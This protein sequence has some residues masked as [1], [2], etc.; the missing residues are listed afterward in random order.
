MV[1]DVFL[2]A[3]HEPYRTSNHPVPINATIVH[4]KTLLHPVV[5]QPD[6]GRMYRCLAEFPGRTP[7]CVVPLSTLTFELDGGLLWSEIGDWERVVDAIVGL[8]QRGACDAVP[9]GLPQAASML[10]AN[11]PNTTVQ[12]HDL[13]GTTQVMGGPERQRQLD[14]ITG[15][16]RTFAAQGAFWP[17]D[18]LVSPP[19]DPPVMPYRPLAS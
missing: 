13:D 10:L 2:L 1:E 15:Q 8:S 5:P 17:G 9:L 6:G 12:I 4:G 19:S 11:G 18:H 3:V 16:V 14:E 7:A